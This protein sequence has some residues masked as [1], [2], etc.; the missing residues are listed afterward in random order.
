MRK[1][2]KAIADLLDLAA[3]KCLAGHEH[4]SLAHLQRV[5][6]GSGPKAE[7]RGDT[8]LRFFSAPRAAT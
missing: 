2:R 4:P 8:T 5:A 3:V 7:N 6:I 1:V